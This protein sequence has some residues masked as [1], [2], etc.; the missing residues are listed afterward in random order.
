MN[1]DKRLT[2]DVKK[3]CRKIGLDLVGFADPIHF[4]RFPKNNRPDYYLQN[5]KSVIIIGIH[6]YDLILDAWHY[7]F[8]GKDNFHFADSILENY[9]YRLKKFLLNKGFNLKVIPYKPGFFLKDSAA[10]AGIGPIGKN[11]LLITKD[12]AS[13]VR[14]RAVITDAPLM[15][16]DPIY[17]NT[18][19]N[20][21]SI[22]H[23]S[24]PANAFPGGKYD[25]ELCLSYNLSNLRKLSEYT[26]IWCNI[27]IES[28]PLRKKI[29]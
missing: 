6:I 26:A 4:N 2:N 12:Y 21:C 20:N 3:Y 22:C 16:G 23:E 13:Q 25:K 15:T 1:R 28:C 19:C 11:N 27:C 5:C 7:Q 18:H 24:C 8:E 29:K 14:L 10:L 9:C 17:E